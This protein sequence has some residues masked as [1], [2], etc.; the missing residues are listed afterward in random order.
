MA[1]PERRHGPK[2]DQQAAVLTAILGISCHY[3]DAAAAL[4]VDGQLV[5]AAEEERFTRNK[6]DSRFPTSAIAFALRQANITADE[7]D[8][9]VFYEKPLSKFERLLTTSLHTVPGSWKMFQESVVSWLTEKLWIKGLIRDKVGFKNKNNILFSEHH[10]S[11]AA[12]A[13]YCSPF[14]KSAV[15][16]A[17]AVGEWATATMGIGDG[18]HLQIL[19]EL[20]FPHS[21]GLLYSAFT[22]FLGFEVNDGE[23]KV[24]GMGAYGEPKYVDKVEKLITLS[25]DGSFQLDLKY[26]S[27]PNSTSRMFN[28][29]FEELFGKPRTA[30]E[31]NN[32]EPYYADLAASVQQVTEDILVKMARHLRQRT[33]ANNICMAGGVALNGL[34]NHRIAQEAGFE[35][36]Y[37]QPAAGDS[38]GA[39]GAALW[40]Y[41]HVLGN[42][43]DFKMDHSYWGSRTTDNEISEYLT[44]A[45]ISFWEGANE[46]QIIDH[47]VESLSQGKVVG[48][49]QGR[50]EWGPRALGNRS[51]LADPR[52]VEMKDIVNEKVKFREPFRPFAPSMLAE[53]ASEF[54]DLPGPEALYPSQFMLYVLPVKPEKTSVIPAVTHADN[55]TRIQAVSQEVNPLYHRLIQKFG[56]ATGVPVVLNTSFNLRG[57]PIVDTPA[58]AYDTF[59]RCDID[60]LV[61]GPFVCEKRT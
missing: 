51:I 20:K 45:G 53:R 27:F 43:R 58:A 29:R 56:A 9:V 40:A 60:S 50:A 52:R 21:V 18:R 31:S 33:G 4:L 37:I 17:D 11:H 42:N 19:E 61:M 10:L 28:S 49:Y 46:D 2:S 48:W 1:A 57:D 26:F 38:G 59:I 24:M 22:A 47:V 55:T 6:H 44:K 16:T 39:L 41:H 5:A 23:Y 14:D 32:L 8:Y 36:V 30:A 7:L 3:H 35:G 34:A 54:V 15:L 13:Y 25:A 12:S